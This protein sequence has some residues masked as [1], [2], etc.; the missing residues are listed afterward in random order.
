MVFSKTGSLI[1]STPL[2]P[3]GLCVGESGEH[4]TFTAI[5]GKAASST[6]AG[7]TGTVIIR[8]CDSPAFAADV[9]TLFTLVLDGVTE[10]DDTGL[11]NAWPDDHIWIQAYCSVWNVVGPQDVRV[12]FFFTE[13]VWA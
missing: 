8:C 3:Q 13:A 1:S 9:V 10:V 2:S 11:D 6:S 7:T 5:R 12:Q 4:G